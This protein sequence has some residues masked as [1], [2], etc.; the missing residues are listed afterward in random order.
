MPSQWYYKQVGREMVGPC[1]ARELKQMA[2][3]GQLLP[4]DRVHREGM[5]KP[6]RARRV[7]GL[8]APAP[9]R[10]RAGPH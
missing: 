10:G 1:T 8:F 9:D 4:T 5:M 7:K 6:V 2:S 3:S